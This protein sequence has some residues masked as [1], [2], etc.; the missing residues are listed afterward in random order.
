MIK[1]RNYF[2]PVG[3]SGAQ[4]LPSDIAG[5]IGLPSI[6]NTYYVD[7]YAGNDT[8]NDGESTT[9]ALKTVAAAFAKCVSGNHDVI[10]ISPTG[11]TGRTTEASAIAWNK[12]FTH[13]IGSAAP[14][15]TSPRAGMNFTATGET[16]TAQ[17]V[18]SE[19]GCIFKNLTIYQGVADSYGG[20][21]LTGNYNYFEGVHFNG[22]SNETAGDS[23]DA[24]SLSFGSSAGDNTFVS[25]TFGNDA[26]IRTAANY[27]VSFP[28][29]ANCARNSFKGCFFTMI[30]DAD[31]PRHVQVGNSGIDRFVLFEGCI[32]TDNNDVT[33]GITQTDVFTN[34][35]GTNDGGAIIVK[36]SMN[37]SSTGWSNTVTGLRIL[38]HSTNATIMTAYATGVNPTA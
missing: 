28:A 13:L 14:T 17:L 20:V 8:N 29:G 15:M 22:I 35:S 37:V 7:P 6:G 21:S 32:F 5:Y 9:S 24:R 33:S 34:D 4:W 31:A 36:D 1:A 18:I 27:S 11:G 25:C 19:N 23:A 30:A 16:T 2:P 26:V 12:R 10:I 3:I 38:G